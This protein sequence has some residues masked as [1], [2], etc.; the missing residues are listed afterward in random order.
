[1]PDIFEN[2]KCTK[3]IFRHLSTKKLLSVK[4][5]S[6]N[7]KVVID[8][9]LQNRINEDRVISIAPF[10]TRNQSHAIAD[11]TQLAGGLTNKTFRVRTNSQL[12]VARQPGLESGLFI[13]RKAESHNA[14]IAG[15]LGVAPPI[16]F[17]DGAGAMI[18][19]FIDQ[20]ET[21]SPSLLKN[22]FNLQSV[23]TTLKKM[24]SS[25]KCFANNCNVFD[26]NRVM[27]DI[28]LKNRFELPESFDFI[29]PII[30][31]IEAMIAAHTIENTPCHNDTTPG[32][33]ILSNDK[34]WIIDWEYSANNDPLWDLVN[35]SMEAAFS[36]E[37]DALMLNTYYGNELSGEILERFNL[38]K[39]VVEYWVVLW[40][41]VQISNK[42]YDKLETLQEL[43]QKRM[44]NCLQI[45]RDEKFVEILEVSEKHKTLRM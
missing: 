4:H 1:M 44:N 27:L 41:M 25:D 16:Y 35:L 14:K 17:T 26:R 23:T 24:H 2:P 33:F 15:E 7:W 13:N 3:E 36:D 11:V 39:P 45:L 21:M 9:H 22:N 12:Y 42:N 30:N 32:N 37:Q 34:M 18:S 20:S 29:L 8:D 6:K 5:V 28:L 31:R 19:R 10:F 40:C 38:Y 43:E